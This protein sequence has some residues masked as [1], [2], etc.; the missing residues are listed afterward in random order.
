MLYVKL[1]WRNLFRNKRRTIIASFA[2]ALGLA[3]LI[4]MDALFIGE[5]KSFIEAATS[6][7]LGEAQ[8]THVDFRKKQT[9]NLTISN[10]SET[11]EKLA[12]DTL[13]AAFTPRT[14]SFGTVTSAADVRGISIHGIAPQSERDLSII[15]E[16]IVD[17]QFFDGDNPRDILIGVKLAEI[18]DVELGDKLILSV[19]Q[20]KTG[21]I[22]QQL[23]RVSGIFDFGDRSMNS[24]AVFIG[25]PQAREMLG[26]GETAH[27]ITIKFVDPN[28]SRDSTA[29]FW[30]NYSV[31]S[32]EAISWTTI[33]PM[34]ASM[35]DMLIVAK[36]FMALIL[37]GIVVFVILNTLFMALYER[38][39]EL[40]VLRAVGTRPMGIVKLLILEAAS[41]SIVGIAMGVVLGFGVTALIAHIG[42]DFTGIEFSGIAMRENIYP[43]L[44]VS[45]F[46]IY[47]IG[48][49][50]FTIIVGIYPA[51][52]AARMSPAKAMKRSF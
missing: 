1:A 24:G 14:Q 33:M 27:T 48:V 39:F 6:T 3:A 30:S 49:F 47:P 26:I 9:S 23:F 38:M 52:H 44:K 10:F 2:I 32:N 17:G 28:I 22:S 34:I 15:D 36:I 21:D 8:I 37:M 42:I 13:V 19:A 41:L 16:V 29:A 12:N 25:L 31:D 50:I 7:F 18:V 40:G 45:Q 20:T 35:S 5:E 11:I 46:I 4:F 51:I 43:V